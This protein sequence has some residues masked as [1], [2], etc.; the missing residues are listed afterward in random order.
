MKISVRKVGVKDQSGY[1]KEVRFE[2]GGA[3]IETGILD[4]DEVADL[5]KELARAISDLLVD[6]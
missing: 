4:T 6:F 5:V 3:T 1:Y 2:D